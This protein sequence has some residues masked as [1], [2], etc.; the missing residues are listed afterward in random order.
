[1][2]KRESPLLLINLPWAPLERGGAFVTFSASVSSTSFTADCGGTVVQVRSSVLVACTF[3]LSFSMGMLVCCSSGRGVVS[4]A[5]FVTVTEIAGA[6]RVLAEREGT[7]TCTV[8]VA[9]RGGLPSLAVVSMFVVCRAGEGSLIFP[10]SSL[11][12]HG[13]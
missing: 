2:S 10:A 3:V 9:V 12:R 11:S 6:S 1:M 4:G 8:V 13:S 5:V 7:V